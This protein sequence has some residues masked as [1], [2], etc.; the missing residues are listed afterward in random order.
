MCPHQHALIKSATACR[1]NIYPDPETRQLRKALGQMHDIPM[2]H[3][4]VRRIRE[5]V[6]YL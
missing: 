5:D 2:E 1:P 3:L 6:F 4:L